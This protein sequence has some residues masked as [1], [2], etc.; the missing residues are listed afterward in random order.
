MNIDEER[1]AFEAAFPLPEEVCWQTYGS[2]G[3][4]C[5]IDFAL[6]DMVQEK[7]DVWLAAKEHAKER[8]KPQA[9]LVKY[10]RGTFVVSYWNDEPPACQCHTGEFYTREEAITWAEEKG[11]RVVNK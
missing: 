9:T 10:L 7:F 6:G 4:F 1:K 11:F 3:Y 5:P 8:A 2:D